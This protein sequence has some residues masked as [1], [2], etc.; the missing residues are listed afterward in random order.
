MG[1]TSKGLIAPKAKSHNTSFWL[2]R[3]LLRRGELDGGLALLHAALA[4]S[5]VV[6]ALHPQQQH[7]QQ[8]KRAVQQPPTCKATVVHFG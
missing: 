3:R 5:F 4:S 6:V 2:L 8:A 1:L 7:Q